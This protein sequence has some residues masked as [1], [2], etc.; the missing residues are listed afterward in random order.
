MNA[1]IPHEQAEG[2]AP[3]AP[4]RRLA[5]AGI[6]L[7]QGWAFI[8][9]PEPFVARP[10]LAIPTNVLKIVANVPM[11]GL[12]ERAI[13]VRLEDGYLFDHR[14]HGYLFAAALDSGLAPLWGAA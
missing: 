14:W 13:A 2:Y 7:R 11:V 4:T 6:D 1:G 5:E 8:H 9:N 12:I 3:A 10:K